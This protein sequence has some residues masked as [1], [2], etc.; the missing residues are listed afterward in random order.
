MPEKKP[1]T[2]RR[3][4][5]LILAYIMF[6]VAGG[7]VASGF[8]LPAV[9]GANAMTK[10][11]T[12]SLKAEDI[13]F[14]LADLPQQSRMYA[15]DG[16][17]V[18][19]TFYE[20]NRIIVPLKNI[21]DYMQKAVVAREDH[22]FWDHSG[23]DPQGIARA[24]VQTYV[25]KGDT[26]GGSTLTQQYVKN[27][28][29]D[30][31]LE[32]NDPIEA[33]HA[34]EETIAR[35]LREMLISVELEK[36]YSKQEILQGYLNIAQFGK[37]VYGVETAAR[38]Y[39]SKSASELNLVE[40]ATIAAIT[41]NPANYDPTVN[42]TESEKQR[43]IT[44]DLMS[45]WGFVDKSETDAAKKIPIADTLHVQDVSVGCQAAGNAA[46]FCDY[47][48]RQIENSK[49]FGETLKERRQL[50]RQG[51]LNIYTTLDVN[52]QNSA[53]TA[54]RDNLPEDDPSGYENILAAIRPGTGEVLALAQNRTYDV[55]GAPG[56]TRTSVNYAVDYKD[57]GGSGFQVGSTWKPI[58]FAAWI[59]A[60]NSANEPLATSMH[61]SYRTI[62]DANGSGVF[63]VQ[64]SG[65]G[66]VNPETP[67]QALNQSHNTTQ[68]SMAQRIGL[69]SIADMAKTMG[70]HRADG[71]DITTYNPS[72]VIGTEPSS[73]LTMANVYAT[74]A[75]NG[76]ACTPIAL[77]KVTDSA[78]KNYK[79]PSADCHQAISSEVAQT[80]AYA[81]NLNVTQGVAKD[82]QLSN[83]R[84]T[85]A[86]TGTSEQT[87]L[88]TSGFVPQVAAFALITNAENSG[89]S[90]KGTIN[91]VY[92]SSWYGADIA[93]PTWK[94]F[95]ENYLNSANIPQNNDYGNPDP[96]MI[97]TSGGS[98]SSTTTKKRSSSSTRSNSTN[99]N[100]GTSG[101][102]GTTDGNTGTTGETTDGQ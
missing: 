38:H 68:V 100:S 17:T 24:F 67:L 57:G 93:L 55:N 19:A 21:S 81:M 11:L 5:T 44:L 62:P 94:E 22:R 75:G 2:A 64:N 58:N 98:S 79:V 39:F 48:I 10:S 3:V 16:T 46:Y 73:P 7:V 53:W 60:G 12:S 97:R 33:Y 20:Q 9:M 18:L 43:N 6:C 91:G 28:L 83:G 27:I 35:K 99:S 85:F 88:A 82:A 29:I 90:L 102:T 23:I 59:N 13:D 34:Q 54:V 36:K 1:K 92:R 74:I 69:K 63:D 56:T 51:G 14:D 26:Q 45:Q 96:N 37:S 50:I 71:T 84:K 86:K 66:T 30:Q 78:G 70:Y 49:V 72:M 47:A 95:M 40:S 87:Q 76:V 31:A 25:K 61:Y 77:T 52:A 32:D 42:P 41:K 89:V 4:F 8:L 65:G 15:S 101:T 80:T